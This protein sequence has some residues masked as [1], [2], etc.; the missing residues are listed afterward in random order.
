MGW[1]MR[2]MPRSA[3]SLT[4]VDRPLNVT[5]LTFR[6]RAFSVTR[7]AA[8]RLSVSRSAFSRVFCV[9]RSRFF[10]LD[11]PKTVA[12]VPAT[13][14]IAVLVIAASAVTVWLATKKLRKIKKANTRPDLKTTLNDATISARIFLNMF[15]NQFPY[16]CVHNWNLKCRIK[17]KYQWIMNGRSAENEL[18]RQLA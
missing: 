18:L 16:I 8:R 14:E 15:A 2:P 13:A 11:R 5:V 17:K 3:A 10:V 9:A 12:V 1:A 7:L 6:M 4:V